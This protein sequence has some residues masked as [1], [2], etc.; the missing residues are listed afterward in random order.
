MIYLIPKARM[1]P[2]ERWTTL[3]GLVFIGLAAGLAGVL[4]SQPALLTVTFSL[5]AA[6]AVTLNPAE[7][8]EYRVEPDG[9]RIGKLFLPFASLQGARVVDL[10][11]MV[12][13]AGLT[14]PGYWA[15]KA[16][17]PGRGRFEVRG[18]TGLGKGVMLTMAD[19]RRMVITPANPV[20]V[21]VQLQV[22]LHQRRTARSGLQ[23]MW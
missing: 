17:A 6:L 4:L 8:L 5:I 20:A 2:V 3:G 22:M 19:G 14:L 12:V 7:Q 1:H 21:A 13:Y 15:G 9:L 16:W 11:G 23:H 18:S 10:R